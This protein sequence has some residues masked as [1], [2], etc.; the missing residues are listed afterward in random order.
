MKTIHEQDYATNKDG[1]V[2]CIS[3]YYSLGGMN[4]FTGANE[5]R[6][7]YISVNPQEVEGGFR[8]TRAFSGTK[9]LLH[10]C[11]RKSDSGARCALPIAVAETP[12]LLDYVLE[13]SGLKLKEAICTSKTFPHLGAV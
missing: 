13:K 11:S 9:K 5:A 6:G 8:R 1:T 2:I 12:R 7:Y 3:V 4:Y 10:K